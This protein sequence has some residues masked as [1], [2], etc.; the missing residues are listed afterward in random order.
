MPKFFAPRQSLKEGFVTFSGQNAEHLRVLRVREGEELT[1]CDGE[2]LDARCVVELASK[3]AFRLRILEVQPSAGEPSVY[4]TVCAALPKGDKT[5]LIVQKAVELGAA[6]IVFFLS[7]RCVAR[8]DGKAAAGR[9]ERLGRVA[10]SSA[11]Q[12]LRGRIPTV[13]WLPDFGKM[14]EEA[15]EADLGAF[16]W[17]EARSV[18]FRDHLR[19]HGGFR[20]AALI[21]GPEGGFSAEEARQAERTGLQ[22]VTLGPRILRCETAPLCALSALM[23]ETGN[24]G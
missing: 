13:H 4:V 12:S 8:P 1:V 20:T 14:L 21:T 22:P 19:A 11:M 10:E 16:L 5:E 7:S 6:R 23:Y 3:D 17:E 9:I 2:G 15:A 18:S 24:L